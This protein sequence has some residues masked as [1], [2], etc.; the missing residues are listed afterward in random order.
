MLELFR[1]IQG[2]KGLELYSD[3][4]QRIVELTKLISD[5]QSIKA[6]TRS[7]L[8]ESLGDLMIYLSSTLNLNRS[9]ILAIFRSTL[10]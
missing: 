4:N 7:E 8:E 6:L 3:Q 5:L 2:T 10:S 1:S 9:E